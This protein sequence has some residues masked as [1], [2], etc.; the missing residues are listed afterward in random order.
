MLG[1]EQR[2][3]RLPTAVLVLPSVDVVHRDGSVA[4]V[5]LL[6]EETMSSVGA[7]QPCLACKRSSSEHCPT[8]TVFC[9]PSAPA[10]HQAHDPRFLFEA[11]P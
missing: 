2:S 3:H 7:E 10:P 11:Q 4:V 1:A 5:Q 6:V 8:F 9:S